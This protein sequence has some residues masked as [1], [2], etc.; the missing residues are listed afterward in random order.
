VAAAVDQMLARPLPRV[1]ANQVDGLSALLESRPLVPHT[2]TSEQVQLLNERFKATEDRADKSVQQ[3]QQQAD[4]QLLALQH[5]L[6]QKSDAAA[7][8]VAT[9]HDELVK[10]I[11]GLAAKEHTHKIQQVEQLSESLAE[12]AAAVHVHEIGAVTGLLEQ[13]ASKSQTNH[14]HEITDVEGLALALDSKALSTHSHAVSEV[15]ELLLYVQEHTAPP[16]HSHEM[17]EVLGMQQILVQLREEEIPRLASEA[18]IPLV[19][20]L[21]KE[22]SHWLQFKADLTHTHEVKQSP[23]GLRLNHARNYVHGNGKQ[24]L[25]GADTPENHFTR[26]FDCVESESNNS[27]I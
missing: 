20:K 8:T 23:T 10:L 21:R 9:Q 5:T 24:Y 7:V 6:Q 4:D 14:Q 2:H 3:Q 13:L 27:S 18:V 11:D 1:H 22:T 19:G 15:R 12:K 16:E 17:S 26:R 25:S